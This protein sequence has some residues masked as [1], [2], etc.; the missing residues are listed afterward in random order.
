VGNKNADQRCLL[1]LT[2]TLHHQQIKS[3][4]AHFYAQGSIL[5]FKRLY[6]R[7]KR[8]V[9]RVSEVMTRRVISVSPETSIRQ[10]LELMLKARISGLPVIDDRGTLVGVISEGD[11]LHRAEIGTDR[12][13]SPW[14]DA[15]FGA[16]ETAIAYTRAH[17]LKVA[18]IM[19]KKVITTTGN[20]P[21]H[22]AVELM[23]H[24][25]IKRLPVMR[26]RRVVGIITRANL[27]RALASIH[28]ATPKASGKDAAIRNRILSALKKQTWSAEI[29]VDVL[30][31]NG[32]VDLWGTADDAHRNALR[33]LVSSVANVKR[34]ND[35]LSSTLRRT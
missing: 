19:T 16:G 13:Y 14:Y 2:R 29:Q 7:E 8:R 33:A 9:M 23:E 11:F 27:M 21:L 10:A 1:Y 31:C 15:F 28:R 6:F 25:H 32:V 4:Y 3:R 5:K 24:H 26:A 22:T 30:V 17:G 12:K 20:S 35:H 34:I 18:E